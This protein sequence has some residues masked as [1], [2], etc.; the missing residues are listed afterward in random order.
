MQLLH[1]HLNLPGTTRK[2]FHFYETIF[3][4]RIARSIVFRHGD[5]DSWDEVLRYLSEAGRHG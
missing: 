5:M 4:T 3:K 1:V 2:A